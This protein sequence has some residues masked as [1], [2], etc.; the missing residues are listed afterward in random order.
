MAVDLKKLREDAKAKFAEA[1]KFGDDHGMNKEDADPSAEDLEAVTKILAEAKDLDAQYLKESQ[2]Q[3]IFTTIEE[4]FKFY[5]EGVLD[6]PLR[7][8]PIMQMDSES[9][10]SLGRQFIESEEYKALQTGGLLK[11]ERTRITTAPVQLKGQHFAAS[12]IVDGGTGAALDR[13]VLPNYLQGI[14]PLEQRPLV[15]RDL[16]DQRPT[17]SDAIDYAQQVA[18]ESA[19]APVAKATSASGVGLTGGVKPQSS[20]DWERKQSPVSTIATWMATTR[21]SLADSPV[22]EGLIDSQGQ[23]MVRLAEEDEIVGGDGVTPNLLGLLN[24]PGVQTLDL[25]GLAE[26]AQLDGIRVA[27]RLIATG[28]SRLQAD[29]VVLTP[30]DSE[31]FDLMKDGN[32]QYRGGNPVGNFTYNQP[33]WGLRRVETEALADGVG[34]VGAFKAGGTV[35]ER[36]GITVY[37]TDSHAD[38]FVR[39]LIAILFEERIGLAVF[40]PSAFVVVTFDNIILGSGEVGVQT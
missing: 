29:G 28:A 5:S 3:G 11:S 34:I 39:N 12:D 23:L 8:H 10:K 36:Q 30:S 6:N 2:K 27:R 20:I 13:L 35:Y 1:K 22:V 21:Q 17:T 40:F 25:T 32:G 15:M 38:F 9:G 19:A 7:L 24:T 26:S 14:I 33:L 18:F 4:R 16:F 31:G 37:T